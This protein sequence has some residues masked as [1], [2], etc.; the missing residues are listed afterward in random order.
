[1][2]R[3]DIRYSSCPER[4][5]C[6]GPRDRRS[7]SSTACRSASGLCRASAPR[8]VR[9]PPPG[10]P[11]GSAL[12]RRTAPRPER[13]HVPLQEAD[14]ALPHAAPARRLVVLS[15]RRARALRQHAAEV[16]DRPHRLGS[17]SP[18]APGG[19]CPP[20]C[21]RARR[22]P[23]G[24]RAGASSR[25]LHVLA[26][27]DLERLRRHRLHVH[28]PSRAS[29]GRARSSSPQTC[30]IA[31]TPTPSTTKSK[32]SFTRSVFVAARRSSQGDSKARPSRSERRPVHELLVVGRDGQRG[33]AAHV[34]QRLVLAAALH[35]SPARRTPAPPRRRAR[36][37]GRR[38]E[39][40]V[41]EPVEEL[42]AHAR[43]ASS[44]W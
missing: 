14:G 20:T 15:L 44:T 40:H 23:R 12:P 9:P 32:S 7:P 22:S 6:S 10:S 41:R 16:R 33:H 42:E 31:P 24:S 27:P 21:R 39:L 35:L 13:A 5:A 8:P 38:R 28:P 30:G 4:I 19:S 17:S 34:D 37:S 18:S 11:S 29:A 1:M 36:P 43:A 3:G 25:A 26:H 2:S